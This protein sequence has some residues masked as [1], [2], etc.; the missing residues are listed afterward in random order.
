V[1]R[2]AN[3]FQRKDAK[4]EG[5]RDYSARLEADQAVMPPCNRLFHRREVGGGKALAS[6]ADFAASH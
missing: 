3:A 6:T 4:G 2:R 1:R 5:A